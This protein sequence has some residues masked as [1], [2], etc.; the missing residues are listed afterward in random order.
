MSEL[1]QQIGNTSAVKLALTVQRLRSKAGGIH[2][3]NAEPIAIIGMGCRFPGGAHDPESYW[4]LLRN[5]VDAI[6]QVPPDRWDV[7][8]FFD[9]DPDAPGKIY[10]R[11]GG[12]LPDIDQF[13]CQFFGISPREA[14]AM[15]PQQRLLLEVSWEALE[16]A[17]QA[18]E[19]LV[20]SQTGV[21]VGI[22]VSEYAQLFGGAGTADMIYAG[23]GNASSVASGR[24]SYALGLQG[25][26]LSV[27]TACSSS[28]VAVHLACQSLRAEESRLALAAGVNL[29]LTPTGAIYFSKMRAMA[30]DGRSKTF[31]AAA[32]G[33]VRSEGCGVVVLKRLSDALADGDRIAGLIRGSAVNHDGRSSGLTVPNGPSQQ[34]VLRAALAHAGVEPS[35][36]SYVE[37]HG[38][39]TPLGDPIEVGALA[40]VYGGERAEPLLIG[41]VK[42]NI[43]H[44]ESAAGIAGLIKTVLAL[45]HGEIPPHLHFKSA[46][47]HMAL[48]KIPAAIPTA[49]TPWPLGAARRFAGVSSFALS[50]TN[51]HVVVEEAPPPESSPAPE[52]PRA[53]L[54]PLSARSPEAFD[55]LAQKYGA[56]LKDSTLP[57]PDICYT[58]AARRSHHDFRMAVVGNSRAELA[59]RL[60]AIRHAERAGT[61]RRVVVVFPEQG[62]AGALPGIGAPVRRLVPAGSIDGGG[63]GR[64]ARTHRCDPARALRLAA[65]S[66]GALEFLGHPAPCRGG[67]QH[68]RSG[69]GARGGRSKPR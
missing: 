41:S 45:Q 27:D 13:D 4:Q 21:F 2:L 40:A 23:T 30:P 10:T 61:G 16:D 66:G 48:E 17:G 52:E 67:T 55:A 56:F 31:D 6:T 14:G 51:A 29:I 15:D 39:G 1:S 49:L 57:L 8:A 37:A 65:S 60:A 24:I 34:A 32:D 35:R 26:T 11:W 19:K 44:T 64:R 54:L 42:T 63:G 22:S 50:G 46:N 69:R 62:S 68:G 25:P 20:G 9:P 28:L 12:F 53:H 38:T 33:Y 5:G 36:V 47:P 18:P 58:A 43:G 7:E 59:G 3:L